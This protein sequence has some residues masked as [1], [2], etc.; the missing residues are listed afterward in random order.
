MMSRRW[1][2]FNLA[3]MLTSL[4]ASAGYATTPD[5]LRPSTLETY[6]QR[7]TVEPRCRQATRSSSA[8]VGKR[9]AIGSPSSSATPAIPAGKP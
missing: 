7:T 6:Q 3:V 1:S 4:S 8:A 9:T 2:V 5:V